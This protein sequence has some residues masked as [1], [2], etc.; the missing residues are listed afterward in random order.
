MP[1]N[2]ELKLVYPICYKQVAA[3]AEPKAE[4]NLSYDKFIAKNNLTYDKWYYTMTV[5]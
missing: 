4:A 1:W 3:C 5:R 2:T